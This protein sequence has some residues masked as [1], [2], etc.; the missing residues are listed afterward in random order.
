MRSIDVKAPQT[1]ASLTMLAVDDYQRKKNRYITKQRVFS[2]DKI[3]SLDPATEVRA[4]LVASLLGN[5]REAQ[6]IQQ[7]F[8]RMV[9]VPQEDFS[10]Q[11]FKVL[12]S[13]V[14]NKLTKPN[15][16]YSDHIKINPKR[17]KNLT[18][19]EDFAMIQPTTAESHQDS[20]HMNVMENSSGD[21]DML[22]LLDE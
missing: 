16:I 1:E 17:V 20:S 22:A 19:I 15:P 12:A 5:S 13:E 2:D 9:E 18:Q 11:S 6:D 10:I 21:L 8:R 14:R 4:G 3:A 7:K